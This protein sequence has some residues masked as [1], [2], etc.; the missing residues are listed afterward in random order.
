[1]DR[2]RQRQRVRCVWPVGD[3]GPAG[4]RR[5]RARV[6]SAGRPPGEAK[7]LLLGFVKELA[8]RMGCGTLGLTVFPFAATGT[9]ASDGR[10][11]GGEPVGRPFGSSHTIWNAIFFFLLFLDFSSSEIK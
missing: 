2:Q 3:R 5:G 4:G 7:G 10:R 1:M 11:V 6:N 9:P 8:H